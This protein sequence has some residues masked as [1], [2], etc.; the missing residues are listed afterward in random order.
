MELETNNNA[1]K[2]PDEVLRSAIKPGNV[3]HTLGFTYADLGPRSPPIN[4]TSEYYVYFHLTEI[5]KLSDGKKRKVNIT[6]NSQSVLSKPLVLDYLKPV[7]LNFK[8]KGD[9]WFN[10]SATSDSDA[11]P[12]LNAFEIHKLITPVVSPTDD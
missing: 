8:T 11:P 5:E 3:S 1:Y 4:P 9:V 6:L 7:T 12:I 10:I 2:L